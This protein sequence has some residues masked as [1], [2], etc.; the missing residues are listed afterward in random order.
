MASKFENLGAL[1]ISEDTIRPRSR[2]S[3]PVHHDIQPDGTYALYTR[4]AENLRDSSITIHNEGRVRTF[5]NPTDPKSPFVF[6]NGGYMVNIN[7]STGDYTFKIYPS[8]DIDFDWI[9][10]LS[11]AERQATLEKISGYYPTIK[12][13]HSYYDEKVK[14]R[15]I[16]KVEEMKV[17]VGLDHNDKSL[18]T[19]SLKENCMGNFTDIEFHKREEMGRVQIL[20][21]PSRGVVT[22]G[23]QGPLRYK[24]IFYADFAYPNNAVAV[25]LDSIVRYAEEDLPQKSKVNEI[26]SVRYFLKKVDPFSEFAK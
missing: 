15:S 11:T 16:D 5:E 6:I 24:P 22:S 8:M 4:G 23:P 17:V 10:K 2:F 25:E 18:Y 9:E 1:G 20:G 13:T 12:I 7:Q 14:K 26:A 21:V 3:T 19:A